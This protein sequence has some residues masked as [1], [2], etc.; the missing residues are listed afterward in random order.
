M[1]GNVA[2]HGLTL[3]GEFLALSAGREYTDRLGKVHQPFVARL[4]CGQYVE[5]V[6]FDDESAALAVVGGMEPRQIVS[7][8]VRA[9]GSWEDGLKRF[10]RVSY[11]GRR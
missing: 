4:L 1:A 3:T 5:S 10:G 8:P 9:R 7:V 11:L 2:E 6:E